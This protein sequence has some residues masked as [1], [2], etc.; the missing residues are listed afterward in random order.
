MQVTAINRSN[1]AFDNN[2][3]QKKTS[4][5]NH[6]ASSDN[7]SNV[8]FGSNE[9]DGLL[10]WSK[11]LAKD[12]LN[13]FKWWTIASIGFSVSIIAGKEF[14]KS[15]ISEMVKPQEAKKIFAT[16]LSK[17]HSPVKDI[18]A[19]LKVRDSLQYVKNSK[20]KK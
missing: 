20:I 7:A 2:L 14:L 12:A 13:T 15:N 18:P 19:L 8:N 9:I 4:N 11:K 1:F 16:Y 17:D 5:L 3:Q 6:T 10:N